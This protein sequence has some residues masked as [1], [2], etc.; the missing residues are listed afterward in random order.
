LRR[1]T[2]RILRALNGNT[3]FSIGMSGLILSVI[4]VVFFLHDSWR[5]LPII[6]DAALFFA[7]VLILIVSVL[8]DAA[9]RK[10]HLERDSEDFAV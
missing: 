10:A 3:L 9:Y 8:F 1:F 2:E 5:G 6:V 7:G 4:S